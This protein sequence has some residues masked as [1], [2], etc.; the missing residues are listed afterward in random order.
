MI[1][2]YSEMNYYEAQDYCRAYGGNV[3]NNSDPRALDFFVK[4]TITFLLR[5]NDHA[6]FFS[7]FFHLQNASLPP[8]IHKY[9]HAHTLRQN[10][11]MYCSY[12]TDRNFF[13]RF[14]FFSFQNAYLP[15]FIHTYIHAHTL[16][17]NIGICDS[18]F[19]DRNAEQYLC[20]F[21][22]GFRLF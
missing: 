7:L 12:F 10:I 13:F 14:C 21:F 8:F 11:H 18:Y 15:P 19:T 3:P 1:M 22:L 20:A 17:Q 2:R 6:F 4:V 5:L 9:I 16:R